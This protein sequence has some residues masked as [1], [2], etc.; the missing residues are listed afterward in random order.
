VTLALLVVALLIA[1]PTQAQTGFEEGTDRAHSPIVSHCCHTAASPPPAPRAPLIVVVLVCR[2]AHCAVIKNQCSAFFNRT[3]I[4]GVLGQG[5]P[6]S[7]YA[8][9]APTFETC[10]ALRCSNC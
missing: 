3:V 7:N 10:V 8:K 9:Y 2:T 1:V 6:Q 4:V 5:T